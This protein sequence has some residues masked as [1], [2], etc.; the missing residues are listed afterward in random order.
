MV[1]GDDIENYLDILE[2]LLV[3]FEVPL[4]GF[5]WIL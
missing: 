1:A 4:R 2:K 3:Q 5:T